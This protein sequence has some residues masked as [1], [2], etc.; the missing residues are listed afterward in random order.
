[1]YE[2]IFFDLDGTLTDP[3]IGI[4]NSVS[5]ALRRSGIE[6]PERSELY[7]FIGPPLRQSFVVCY[8]MSEEESIKA[9]EYYR[10]YYKD[11]G[12]FENRVYSG[13][14]EMLDK[15]TAEGKK[16]VLAT[17]KPTLYAHQILEHFGL[18]KYFCF[19]A[20]ANMDDSRTNKADVIAY[21]L[22]ECGIWDKTDR[23][24]MVGDREHD[25]IGAKAHGVSAVG[26]TYG[27]GSEDELSSAGALALAASPSDVLR[28][29]LG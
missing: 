10:E 24:I 7:K 26:V 29:T 21:A 25:I 11:K 19:E 9:V 28:L 15:L 5:H 22:D 2:Y 4:T 16:I 17:S 1:M 3:G 8:G 27:Y 18:L 13:V 14:Y 23:I 6:P 20:G 12:I